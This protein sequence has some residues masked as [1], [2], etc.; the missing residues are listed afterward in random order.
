MVDVSTDVAGQLLTKQYRREKIFGLKDPISP[1]RAPGS[2]CTCFCIL[3]VRLGPLL[4]TGKQLSPD[5]TRT[6]HQGTRVQAP[7]PAKVL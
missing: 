6:L 4:I 7:D 5:I 1:F 2:V 3:V